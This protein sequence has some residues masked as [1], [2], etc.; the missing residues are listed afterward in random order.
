L[1]RLTVRRRLLASCD[2]GVDLALRV[3]LEDA[4]ALHDLADELVAFARDET[5]VR[6][7]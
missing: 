7:P 2:P 3:V 5:D 6:H 4:V 1:R